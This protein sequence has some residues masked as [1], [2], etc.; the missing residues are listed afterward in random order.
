MTDT[1]TAQRITYFGPEATFT[2]QAA[3]SKFGADADMAPC[4][5]VTDVFEAVAAG[6]SDFG[7]VPVENS[8]E[9]VVTMTF[10]LF[11]R[12]HEAGVQITDEIYLPI[13]HNL[14]VKPGMTLDEIEK[15]YSHPQVLG[16]CRQWLLNSMPQ[17]ECV[18]ASS[19]SAASTTAQSSDGVAALA[20]TLAAETY[21]LEILVTDVED[22]HEN[23]TRFLVL[24]RRPTTPS[25]DDRTSLMFA[26]KDKVGALYDALLPFKEYGVNMSMIQSRPSKQKSWEYVFFV[27]FIGHISESQS[28]DAV[29]GL[30]EHCEFVEVLGSY[31]RTIRGKE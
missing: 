31:P 12:F 9:G 29:A 17:C 18:A 4:S 21:G 22:L 2:H 25:G 6:R 24:S 13:H 8:T 20:G 27:D 19:T 5:T 30:A 11:H 14:L 3:R 7:V 1:T 16:Q 28:A 26:T 15:I 23:I 10:D